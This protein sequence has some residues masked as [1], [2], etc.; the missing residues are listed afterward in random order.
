MR[1]LSLVLAIAATILVAPLAAAPA[2]AP[3]PDPVATRDALLVRVASGGVQR[4]GGAALAAAGLALDGL[5]PARLWLR[6]RGAAVPVELRIGDDGRLDLGDELRFYAPPPGDRWNVADTYWLTVEQAPAPTMARRHVSPGVAPARAQAREVGLA[7]AP[8]RYE[9]RLPGPD[10]DHWFAADLRVDP[11]AVVTHTLPLSPTLPPGDGVTTITV[12]G[13]LYAGALLQLRA[14]LG[15]AT[16]GGAWTGVGAQVSTFGLAGG[17][18]ALTVEASAPGGRAAALLDRVT[19]ERPARLD[20]GGR[21]AR[22]LGVAGRWRYT[23]AGPPAGWALYDV[24]DPAAPQGLDTGG[25]ATFED[26]PEPRAYLVAGPGTLHEPAITPWHASEIAAP[27]TADVVYI[28]PEALRPALGP[29]VALREAQGHAVAVV[30]AEAIYAAWSHGAVDPEAIRSF[31]RYA[32]AT[33]QRP[34]RYA[35]LVGD[36]SSDPH[37]WTAHGPLNVNLIPP[38]L[39]PVD[40]WLGEAACDTCYGRLAGD[41]PIG[42]LVPDLIVGRLP[43]KSAAELAALAAKLAAHEAASDGVWRGTL[44]LLAEEQDT[45][46]DFV[47]AAELAVDLMPAGARVRRAYYDPSGA[48]GPSDAVAAHALARR[49][50]DEGAAVLIYHGHSHQWQWALTDPDAERTALLGLYDPDSLANPG[51]LPAVLAMTCLSSAF[52]TPARSG[53]TVD[54]RLVLA[55]GG[56]AAVWGPAGFGVAHGH[57]QLQAGFLTA[58]RDA[59]GGRATVGELAMAGYRALAASDAARDSLYTYVLL[60]DP[61]TTVRLHGL[62]RASL[63]SLTR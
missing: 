9:S 52:Q 57:A 27:R 20:L 41:S 61:L 7:Y 44:A 12:T 21:G 6:H 24:S 33:W 55:K 16:A 47:A 46:G 4:L 50:F 18:T 35:V 10:G 37:D 17:A 30:G 34:P 26:G 36:G 28:T 32:A 45:A 11:G 60:G 38:Y 29:L 54:E 1:H 19:W 58:L 56:A 5:D 48:R 39:A 49:V 14:R 43:V 22:F 23:L 8:A 13:Q 31:L 42:Q 63:P 15:A 59:P 62:E 2:P 51:R 3:L 25:G 53:T 40:P